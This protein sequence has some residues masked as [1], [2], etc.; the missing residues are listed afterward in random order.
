MAIIAR[1]Q[2]TVHIAEKGDP[3][4]MGNWTAYVFISSTTQPAKPT[5]TA[6]LP[7][8]WVDA[9]TATGVWWIMKS[10]IDP[11][12]YGY[13]VVTKMVTVTFAQ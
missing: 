9:P 12:C 1:G 7:S 8:G 10:I 5:G 2:I 4:A 3:G 13:M 11:K 6:P